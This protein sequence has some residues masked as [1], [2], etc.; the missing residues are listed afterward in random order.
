MRIRIGHLA[1]PWI[2]YPA[3][4]QHGAGRV[5]DEIVEE[6]AAA[7]SVASSDTSIAALWTIWSIAVGATCGDTPVRPEKS[8]RRAST[9]ALAT[10]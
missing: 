9:R 3:L 8:E 1:L 7:A 6:R 4:E 5:A 2:H 10:L